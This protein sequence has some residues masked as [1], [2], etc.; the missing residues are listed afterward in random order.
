[1]STGPTTWTPTGIGFL[2]SM[3]RPGRRVRRPPI[4]LLIA[5]ANGPG[6]TITTAGAG[7]IMRPGAGL[8]IITAAGSGMAATAGAGGRAR[9][10]ESRYGVLL[11]WASLGGADSGLAG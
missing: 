9:G 4:G 1:M 2:R 11:S 10:S 7:S 8:L 5:T 3:G 6:W